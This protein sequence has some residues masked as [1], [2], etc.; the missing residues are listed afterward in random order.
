LEV[1]QSLDYFILDKAMEKLVTCH[2]LFR[3]ST[4]AGRIIGNR[5]LD[6]CPHNTTN[7][8]YSAIIATDL[9]PG[10]SMDDLV[11][12]F[13]A[14]SKTLKRKELVRALCV[15]GYGTVLW[16]FASDDREIKPALFMHDLDK[17]LVPGYLRS[18][19]K[20][21]VFY[22]LMTNLLTHLYNSVLGAEDIAVAN[23][24]RENRISVP[25]DPEI[26]LDPD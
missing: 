3:P 26:C 19:D 6:D 8:L 12:R 5:K 9:R 15:L 20:E 2:R 25:E 17:S 14:V 24:N 13:F 1:K 16:G 18:R 11:N 10:I 21:S 4:E 7:P 23:G 22:I